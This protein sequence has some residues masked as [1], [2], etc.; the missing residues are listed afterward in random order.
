MAPS[1]SSTIAEFHKTLD[2]YIKP[3]EQVNYIRRILALELGSYIG[4][5]PIQQ[6]L[7]FNNGPIDKD[8]GPEL[9]GLH[10][11]YIEAL[12]ANYLARQQFE[13]IA[14]ETTSNSITPAKPAQGSTSSLL[15]EHLALLKLRRK[16]ESLVTIQKYLDCLSEAPTG[17]QS[18]A[19]VEKVL[20]GGKALPSVPSSVINS[21]VV[22]QSAGQPDVRSRVNQLDKIVLRTKLLLKQEDHQLAEAR[23]RCKTKPDVSNGAKLFALN[24]TRNELITWIETELG[25]ASTEEDKSTSGDVG[26]TEIDQAAITSQLQ[27]IQ[28]EYKEYV[29]ARKALL[30]LMS[31]TPQ[32]SL[33]PPETTTAAFSSSESAEVESLPTNFLLTPHIEAI[34]NQ[35]QHQ[36]ALI[37]HKSYITAS[38]STR[39]RE[40]CQ[41]LG[42]LAEESQLLSA[43]PMKDT[44]RRRS[45][46]PEI[47]AATPTDR[48]DITSRVKPWIFASDAAKI[49]TLETV[50]EKVEAGQVAL[51]N[52][53]EAIQQ[54]EELLGLDDERGQ[55]DGME[56]AEDDMWLQGPVKKPPTKKRPSSNK[57]DPWAR[58]HGNLG[59]IGH[60]NI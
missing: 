32:P 44:I 49:S 24:S 50:A 38:L 20:N 46:I 60:D 7:A 48:P 33:P 12:R 11:E 54:I 3:R 23:A 35:F 15:E 18:A 21:F 43:Y 8:V 31:Q 59:L 40:S 58:I 41:L 27:Q 17:E 22:E 4:E 37:T 2:S 5:G 57:G 29:A 19:D 39:N 1:P 16:H 34:F 52:S 26:K 51:E 9:K 56:T 28:D 13:K 30:Q 45:G 42:R 14:N 25:K 10:E 6:P 53:M 36:K 55:K 47:I